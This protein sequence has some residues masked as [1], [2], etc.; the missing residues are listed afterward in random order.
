VANG[1]A[2]GVHSFASQGFAY[3]NNNNYLTMNTSHGSGAMTDAS[4]Q[5]TSNWAQA[6][7]ADVGQ[8][9]KWHPNLDG[10]VAD[11]DFRFARRSGWQ[12]ETVMGIYN[13]TQDMDFL[14]TF[15]LMPQSISDR[16]ARVDHRPHGGDVT[17]TCLS[18]RQLV[19]Y[20]VSRTPAGQHG[21]R[22]STC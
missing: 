11:Y 9:G 12:A 22:F 6:Y 15:A 7:I 21:W 8:L 4:V 2:V 18:N 19:L 3:S 20:C 10:P 13:D 5:L 1:R 17:A 16:Y 14:H